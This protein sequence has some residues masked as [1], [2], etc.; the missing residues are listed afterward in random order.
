MGRAPFLTVFR[1]K[2]RLNLPTITPRPPCPPRIYKKLYQYLESALPA[3][4]AREP[5]TPRKA[6]GSAP[7]SARTTP[8]TPLSARKTPRSS[9]KDGDKAQEPPEWTMRTIRT[10]LKAFSFPN[11]APHIYTGVESIV[12]LLAR[13]SAAVA[14][15][16]SKRPRRAASALPAANSDL[17]NSRVLGLIAVLLFY[18]LSRMMDKDI[19]PEQYLEWRSKAVSTLL[20]SPPGKDISEEDLSVE[21]E[22]LMPMAQEEGWLQMEWFLNVLPPDAGE[23]M[24]GVE[25]TD[26][27]AT[28][29][30][31]SRGLK[32]GGS[33]YIGLGTMIQDA[34][35][36]LS[37]R[38]REDYRIWKAGILARVEE[39]EAS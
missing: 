33:D 19:T 26:G 22:Q 17:S 35:D 6:A 27:H 8:K 10:L 16:P 11:A 5:Q 29:G 39:I 1:L 3:S 20:K 38:Q 21:I 12:P 9:R 31:K 13:M 15:T 36:Y 4:T 14:E 23:E 2:K 24:E 25:M 7:A 18:V 34:T 32:D 30:A 37:E 28:M